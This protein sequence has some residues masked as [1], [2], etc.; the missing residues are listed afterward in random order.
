ML[1]QLTVEEAGTG[2]IVIMEDSSDDSF[3]VIG[4]IMASDFTPRFEDD[5]SS[6]GQRVVRIVLKSVMSPQAKL[7]YKVFDHMGIVIYSTLGEAYRRN[8]GILWF[9]KDIVV[10]EIDGCTYT[11]RARSY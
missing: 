1:T 8:V 3:V 7:L 5:S 9:Q 6:F 11:T 4:E 2:N 10:T